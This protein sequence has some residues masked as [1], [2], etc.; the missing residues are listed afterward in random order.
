MAGPDDLGAVST[1]LLTKH[2]GVHASRFTPERRARFLRELERTCSVELAAQAAGVRAEYARLHRK[3]DPELA[4]EWEA[5]L[6]RGFDP[7]NYAG[8]AP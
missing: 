6:D 3:H 1:R 2:A 4:A 8:G 5:A 7:R